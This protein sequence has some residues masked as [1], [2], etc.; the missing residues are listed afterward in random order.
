MFISGIHAHKTDTSINNVISGNEIYD[1]EEGI[2]I[3]E[4]SSFNTIE[5]NQ[6]HGATDPNSGGINVRA[7]ENYIYN[8]RS[9]NNAGA[10]FRF[11]G[12]VS[13]A[14]A[15]YN[16][17]PAAVER[18]DGLPPYGETRR[19]VARVLDLVARTSAHPR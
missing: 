19:F 10:G 9:Y 12:D 14:L 8:N 2:D 4:D 6:I 18:Y 7:D 1:V 16:A 17:G 5:N 11:G 3:K 13:L 15:A